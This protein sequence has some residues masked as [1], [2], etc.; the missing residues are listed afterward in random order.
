[1][2]V[3]IRYHHLLFNDELNITLIHNLENKSPNG[4]NEFF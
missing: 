3:S 4:N 2:N 1:M